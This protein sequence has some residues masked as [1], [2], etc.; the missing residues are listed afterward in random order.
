[1]FAGYILR[2]WLRCSQ[3]SRLTS[4]FPLQYVG[5]YVVNWPLKFRWSR[6]YICN[7]SY[8]QYQI[9]SINLYHCCH[10]S[11]VVCPGLLYH[12]ML[13]ISY[14]SRGSWCCASLSLCSYVICANNRVLYGP[15]VLFV[16]FYITLPHYRHYADVSESIELLKCLSGTFCRVCVWD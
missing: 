4:L 15:M 16:S 14:I 5:L 13:S 9:R 11:M 8:Y 3:S 10:I 1:M 6:G 12:H 2:V 7:S